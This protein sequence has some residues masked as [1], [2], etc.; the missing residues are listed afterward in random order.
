[1]SHELHPANDPAYM[2][3]AL[4][5]ALAQP[6]LILR[7][8]T[9]LRHKA[10]RRALIAYTIENADGAPQT[11]LGKQR[12]KGVD[13]HG[14]RIQRALWQQG[15]DLPGVAVPETLAILPDARLWLQRQVAGEPATHQLT[16][17]SPPALWSH[18]GAALASLHRA[19]IASKRRWTI[20]D[21]L[22]LLHDRLEK[23][24]ALRPPLAA[25]I[26]TLLPALDALGATLTD[27]P[28]CGIH[29]DCYPDQILISPLPCRAKPAAGEGWG[30]GAKNHE[31]PIT[32]TWLDL[33]LYAH[34]DPALDAGNFLAHMTEHALRYYHDATALAAQEE[35]LARQWLADSPLPTDAP[36]LAAWTTLALARHIY[37]STQFPARE[38]TT[39]PL[40]ALCERRLT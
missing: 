18:I 40:L 36:T 27:R 12:A 17:D 6:A 34:G 8:L 11:I 24:A 28:T 23:A 29:R 2:Q 37:L 39:A 19:N 9:I 1:M 13:K 30:G 35:A 25:R 14:Y 31:V 32:L 4:R 7:D 10:G 22:T 33:D 38:H 20:A 26:R 3:A 16:P 15:F 5:A 21:E